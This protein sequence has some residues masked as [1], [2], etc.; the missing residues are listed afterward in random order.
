LPLAHPEDVVNIVSRG[1]ELAEAPGHQALRARSTRSRPAIAV[2]PMETIIEWRLLLINQTDQ[3]I[4]SLILSVEGTARAQQVDASPPHEPLMARA[5][6]EVIVPVK[7]LP[8]AMPS[9]LHLSARVVGVRFADG[10][11]LGESGLA[12]SP[13]LPTGADPAPAGDEP[14]EA[15]EARD[16]GAPGNA[17][18]SGG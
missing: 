5:P 7:L 18:G 1:M 4:E 3:Q 15:A 6:L 13:A 8:G 11:T 16:P 9:S 12:R 2:G 17:G 14:G 10:S